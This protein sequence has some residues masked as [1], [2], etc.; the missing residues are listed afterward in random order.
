LEAI[1]PDAALASA[2]APKAALSCF[3]DAGNFD[4]I[5]ISFGMR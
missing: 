1:A 4:F 5:E 2:N 3:H